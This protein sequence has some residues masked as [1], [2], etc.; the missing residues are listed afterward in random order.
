MGAPLNSALGTFV[1]VWEMRAADG[2]VSGFEIS[3]LLIGRRGV[4]RLVAKIPGAQVTKRPRL[5]RPGD[6]D[7]IC[8]FTVGASKF[9]VIEPFGDNGRYWIC[10]DN[11]S[12]QAHI[13]TVRLVFERHKPFG[14][15]NGRV[16]R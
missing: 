15:V 2:R 16:D 6:P 14:L 10:A 12:A 1:R 8:H 3:N 11:D 9:I 5:W 7:D 4:T 13:N